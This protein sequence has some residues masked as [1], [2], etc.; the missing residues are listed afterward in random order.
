MRA[1]VVAAHPD[2]EILGCGGV[3][4]RFAKQDICSWLLVLT[5]GV[6]SRYAGKCPASDEEFTVRSKAMGEAAVNVGFTRVLQLDH[7][8][9][10]LDTVPLL[11]LAKAVGSVIASLKPDIVFCPFV[12]D[13]NIDHELA[14]RATITATRPFSETPVC[15]VLMYEIASSTG[16]GFGS[17]RPFNPNVFYDLPLEAWTAKLAALK[18]Y[19]Y[20][21][22]RSAPRS[23]D[24][25]GAAALRWGALAGCERA[26]AFELVREIR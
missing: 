9:L 3:I 22:A 7:L 21:L 19:G 1:L 25:V 17:R 8:D 26:E 13:L 6:T 16:A 20:E 4:S 24:A 14:A 15:Q 10:Q 11:K 18:A 2:D 23:I 12:G 5:D